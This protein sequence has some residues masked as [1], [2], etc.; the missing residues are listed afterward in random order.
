MVSCIYVFSYSFLFLFSG[1]CSVV[2]GR[3][4]GSVVATVE[5]NRWLHTVYSLQATANQWLA[6]VWNVA[7]SG[8]F[9]MIRAVPMVDF[10]CK[11]Q[12]NYITKNER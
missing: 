4:E 11:V 8:A 1:A 10:K 3:L 9:G 12:D 6:W 2:A 5:K 7:A